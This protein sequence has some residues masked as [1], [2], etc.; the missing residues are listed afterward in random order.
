MTALH[1]HR[2]GLPADGASLVLLHGWGMHSGIWHGLVE[3]LQ[4]RYRLYCIDLPGHG[5]SPFDSQQ[6]SLPA[7]A[8]ALHDAITGDSLDG[9]VHLLG[10]SLGGM[11]AVQYTACFPARVASLTL[12]A[13]NLSFSR[14]DDWPHAMDPEVL[15]DFARQLQ[16]DA[17]QTLQHFL[18]LQVLAQPGA[19]QTLH[20]LREQLRSEVPPSE[21]AL[22]AGLRILQAADLRPLATEIRQPV[23][24]LGGKGDRLVPP[25]ALENMQALLANARTRMIANS[26]HAPFIARPDECA[27]QIRSF[28]E[29]VPRP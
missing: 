6:A 13:S 20:V 8:E 2:C 22:L 7:M 3:Q 19:R 12:I 29:H 23:L 4:D 14:R 16:R 21:P 18:G 27:R 26:G 1:V 28:I 15:A 17:P 24:L 25:A 9:P 5:R 11:L 10:W